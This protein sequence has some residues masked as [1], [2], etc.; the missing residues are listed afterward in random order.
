[1][2]RSFYI[3][4]AV[5]MAA[6]FLS[7]ATGKPLLLSDLDRVGWENTLSFQCYLSAELK[8]AKLPDP[9]GATNVSFSPEGAARIEE[10]RW[11]ITLPASLE[12][13]IL[14]FHKRDQYVYVAFEEGDAVLPFSRDR[15]DQFSLALTI[16]S[17]YENG[18]PFV[19]YEGVRYRPEYRGAQLPRLN[20]V[21][22]ETESSL[23]RQM[24]G[25]QV[26]SSSAR[27]D[28]VNRISEKFIAALSERSV[29]AVLN[30]TAEDQEA[31][32]LITGALEHQLVDSGKFT[33]VDRKS[34]DDLRSE[35]DFQSSGNV[36]DESAISI[37]NMLG[38]SIVVTGDISG[39]GASRRLNVKALDVK[40]GEIVSS[41]WEPL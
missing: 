17:E 18:V 41:G 32:A 10:A 40:T 14:N 8:L 11:T 28:A 22:V 34:L 37:G 16:D 33:I 35:Q 3:A 1:M 15:N 13:R 27:E 6:F 21:I 19:E 12:G 36:S 2:K 25:S 4:F 38:A 31:A 26:R 9:A 24:Q 23:R 29:I 20:V 5:L 7:C 30:I 39:A